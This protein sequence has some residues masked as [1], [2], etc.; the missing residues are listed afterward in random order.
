MFVPSQEDLGSELVWAARFGLT[1]EVMVL[2]DQGADIV[3]T[4]W[5]RHVMFIPIAQR[6]KHCI[7]IRLSR[8]EVHVIVVN[9]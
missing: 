6:I 7:H 8:L 3:A 4:D 5:V 2:L 1:K 9:V